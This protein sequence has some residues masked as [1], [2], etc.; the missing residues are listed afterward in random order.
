MGL[1]S[2]HIRGVEVDPC[3]VVNIARITHGRADSTAGPTASSAYVQF[4][5]PAT[6]GM[7]AWTVG[8]PITINAD[9]VVR[10]T[11]TI[12][13]TELS[14]HIPYNGVEHGV[15]DVQ[16]IG[17]VATLGFREIGDVPW[18]VELV[19][20]RATHILNPTGVPYRVEG[21]PSIRVTTRDVD[22]QPALTLITELAQ[23]VGAAVFDTPDGVV[24]FQHYAARA[25]SWHFTRWMDVPPAVVWSAAAG[26]WAD[27][28]AT[29][30]TSP[31]A[32]VPIRLDMCAVG[33]EPVWRETSGAVINDVTLYYGPTPADG[34]TRDGWH[35]MDTDSVTL[36]GRRHFGAE[37]QLADLDGAMER[38]GMILDLHSEPRWGMAEIL[39]YVDDL[40]PAEQTTMLGLLCGARVQLTDMPQPAPE[41]SPVRIVEGWTHTLTPTRSDLVLQVSDPLHS[42]AG[43]TWGA[44]PPAG[45]TPPLRWMDVPP[46]VIWADALTLA[47][48]QPVGGP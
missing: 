15:F 47:H 19:A 23:D 31:N 24:V 9:G 5:I 1:E 10:F 25:Q 16:A 26:H 48:L 21:A 44:L 2:V 27:W 39:V 13:D 22:R 20:D 30:T 35:L 14:A 38:A 41:Y 43:I 12:T 36:H 11:G 4:L 32:P 40:P 37:T 46:A 17:N 6:E 34:G 42:Y 7:P 18:P 28:N 45:T 8:D 3:D 29:A 33:W